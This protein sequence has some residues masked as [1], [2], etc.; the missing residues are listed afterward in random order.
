MTQEYF[1][2]QQPDPILTIFWD[3]LS[4]KEKAE[5]TEDMDD[6]EIAVEPVLTND[7]TAPED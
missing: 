2:K 7:D 6:I 3:N 1:N 5:L 4:D